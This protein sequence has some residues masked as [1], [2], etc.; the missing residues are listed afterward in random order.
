M[1]K[2]SPASR[3][4]QKTQQLCVTAMLTAL[5]VVMAFTPV[6]YLSIGIVEISFL[7]IP[8]AIGGIICGPL[9]S[10][11]L[12]FIF[13]LTSFL[14]CFGIIRP[15]VFGEAL[16]A[17]NPAGCAAVCFIPRILAGL[18][19]AL[20]FKAFKGKLTAVSYATASLSA[21]VL[22]TVLF[23]LT[24]LLFF[25]TSSLS[26]IGLGSNTLAVIG[27][28]ITANALIEWAA[29]LVIGLAVSKAIAAILKKI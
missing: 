10:A 26:S 8:V 23:T 4:K 2:L 29:C 25:K 12:G 16:L 13:G 17:I 5:I 9:C 6:G 27:A 18:F 15:S 11:F 24:L 22:N 21:G 19:A 20:I 28:L 7:S 14:Q 3:R 1:S